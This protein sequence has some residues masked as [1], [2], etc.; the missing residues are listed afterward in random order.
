MIDINQLPTIDQLPSI[1][2]RFRAFAGPGAGK[3][4]WLIKHVKNVL[5]DSKKLGVTRRIAC[6]TYTNI[7]AEQLLS[8]MDC[9][10]SQIEVCTIH[11]FLYN[12]VIKPFAHLIKTDDDGD[13]LFNVAEMQGHEEHI[14]HADR[15]R[16]WLSTIEQ[17]SGKRQNYY[18]YLN[19][20]DSKAN[21]VKYLGGLD[22]KFDNEGNIVLYSKKHVNVAVPSSN[23]ELWIYKKKYWS[24]GVMHHED[25][26]YFANY[27]IRKSPRVLDFIRNRFPYI[28]IDE[29]QDTTVL[30]TSIVRKIADGDMTI[31]IIGDLAQSIYKFAGAV[32]TDFENLQLIG[33][34]SYKLEQNFRSSQSIID[35]LN[36][37]RIDIQ[38]RGYEDTPAGN[39][40][41]LLVGSHS[42][43]YR[44]VLD[45]ISPDAIALAPEHRDV[46]SIRTAVAVEGEHQV[47]KMF[48][49]DSNS[50]RA[51]Y[52][53]LLLTGY[54]WLERKNNKQ[55]VKVVSQ[56][57]KA[58]N[59]NASKFAI[60]KA[61]IWIL[62]ELKKE[63]SKR[64]TVHDF[65]LLINDHL[66]KKFQFKSHARFAAGG[67]QTFYRGC[68]V[69]EMLPFVKVDTQSDEKIR[70]IHSAKGTEFNHVLVCMQ[71]SGD[72]ER[73]ILDAKA[74]LEA[75]S[76]EGR[77][78]YVGF[79]RAKANLIIGVPELKDKL[80]SAL[81]KQGINVVRL[82]N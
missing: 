19:G 55:A 38:Q 61:S 10:K 73:Y 46:E 33:M 62:E 68:S 44:W 77:V 21:L 2:T 6:I 31:G 7:A 67:A 20:R 60:Q 29:F 4:T 34:G 22:Y 30:Q 12:N 51:R 5:K 71:S 8:R 65:Y 76:D 78:Y 9:D 50:K 3:T 15:I 16:R 35:Y 64:L 36:T 25:V 54:R 37:L 42:Q 48:A 63:A 32:R 52:I 75:P 59:P 41:T 13:D 81:Y 43:S 79:S 70:T 11:S 80:I 40:I 47:K 45:N 23:R 74:K 26:L 27:I 66:E 58:L 82:Q 28:F 69:D 17:R 18:G 53:H 56:Q 57:L 1:E 24:D 49:E 39:P 14:P 72:I